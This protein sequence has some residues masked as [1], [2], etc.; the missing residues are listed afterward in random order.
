[1]QSDTASPLH[2]I[3][4]LRKKRD[5]GALER[6]RNSICVCVARPMIPFPWT[7]LPRG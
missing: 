3:D 5:G 7:S 2:M 6:A 4:I 1:M